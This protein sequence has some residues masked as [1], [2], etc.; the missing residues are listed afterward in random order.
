MPLL[1]LMATSGRSAE[2]NALSDVMFAAE[3]TGL[4]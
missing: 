1:A 4:A 3:Q 2:T